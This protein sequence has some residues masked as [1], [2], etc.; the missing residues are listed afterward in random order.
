MMWTR[1]VCKNTKNENIRIR[2]K[3]EARKNRHRLA[4]KK[5]GAK[6]QK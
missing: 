2:E 4:L 5:Y 3:K 1:G 6:D